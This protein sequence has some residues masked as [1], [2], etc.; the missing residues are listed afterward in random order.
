[1]R[2]RW[3]HCDEAIEIRPEEWASHYLLAEL[4]ADTDRLVARNQI[5][6]ALELNPLSEPARKLATDLGV[7]PDTGGL[8]PENGDAPAT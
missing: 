3:R 1:M 6:V 7:D 2:S 8:L 4:Q 5:R